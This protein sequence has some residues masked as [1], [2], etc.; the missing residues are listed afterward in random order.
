MK[1]L[2][3]YRGGPLDRKTQ[4]DVPLTYCQDTWSVEDKDPWFARGPDGG[5]ILMLGPRPKGAD[6]LEYSRHI[7]RKVGKVHRGYVEYEF[8]ETEEVDRCAKVLPALGRRCR[9]EAAPGE[10]LC[11]RHLRAR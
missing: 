6:W 11:V 7:Y 1:V 3:V 9:N 4:E 2:C 5:A 8:V 10:E